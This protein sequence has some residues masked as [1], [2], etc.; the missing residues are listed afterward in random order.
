MMTK[1]GQFYECS[2]VLGRAYPDDTAE[3]PEAA[4]NAAFAAR[5]SFLQDRPERRVIEEISYCIGREHPRF[6]ENVPPNHTHL[7]VLQIYLDDEVDPSFR[8]D[9]AKHDWEMAAA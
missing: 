4:R 3:W 9:E 2:V 6:P 5:D 1:L 8:W 7:L